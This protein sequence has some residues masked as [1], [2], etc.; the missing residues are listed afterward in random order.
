MMMERKLKEHEYMLGYNSEWQQYEIIGRDCDWPV[1]EGSYCL[2]VG[3]DNIEDCDGFI[4]SYDDTYFKIAKQDY[5]HV[6]GLLHKAGQEMLTIAKN[7]SKPL[8][9]PLTCG[10]FIFDSGHFIYVHDLSNNRQ[11]LQV[12]Q[13][14]Y[15]PD[16]YSPDYL[17]VDI[18]M[19]TIDNDFDYDRDE[20]ESRCF[21]L[22]EDAFRNALNI[23]NSVILEIN[24]YLQALMQKN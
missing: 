9:R 2:L 10:D 11:K 24:D 5:Q 22:S 14:S 6:L 3:E 13:F 15:T 17:D 4:T 23:G 19:T 8:D 12:K 7:N 1:G 16:D 20:W 21:L 18:S